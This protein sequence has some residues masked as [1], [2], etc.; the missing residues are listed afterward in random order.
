MNERSY[1][2]LTDVLPGLGPLQEVLGP[3][4]GIVLGLVWALVVIGIVIY[5]FRGAFVLAKAAAERRPGGATHAALDL[6]LPLAAL[7]VC[8][9]MPMLVSAVQA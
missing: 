7:L 4:I 8:A 3:K 9:I 1:N 2:P 6:G 5:A